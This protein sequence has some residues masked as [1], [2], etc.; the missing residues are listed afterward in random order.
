MLETRGWAGDFMV[1][2]GWKKRMTEIAQVKWPLG[3]KKRLYLTFARRRRRFSLS[4]D[5]SR[6]LASSAQKRALARRLTSRAPATG[7]KRRDFGQNAPAASSQPEVL[8]S[9][10]R[11]ETGSQG[12]LVVQ[13]EARRVLAP[14][15]RL[16][17]GRA[18]PSVAAPTH[19]RHWPQRRSRPRRLGSWGARRD[20]PWA[21]PRRWG[22]LLA[23]A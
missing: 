17:L 15:E 10:R 22:G 21:G 20:S 18:Q 3:L 1:E 6:Y 5:E 8:P 11:S 9:S 14:K 16:C 4:A 23:G 12:G 19:R 2:E 13:P 7:R